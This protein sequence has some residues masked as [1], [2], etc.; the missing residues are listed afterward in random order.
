[1]LRILLPSANSFGAAPRNISAEFADR[2]GLAM[3]LSIDSG[4]FHSERLAD[5]VVKYLLAGAD[6]VMTTSAILEHGT[7]HMRTLVSGLTEWLDRRDL[8]DLAHVR[9]LLSQGKV[10]NPEAYERANYIKVLQSYHPLGHQIA[11]QR[12][13]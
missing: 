7:G 9:G 3:I 2:L 13:A 10:S 12:Q 4:V 8:T 5:D 1:M 6:V 11:A